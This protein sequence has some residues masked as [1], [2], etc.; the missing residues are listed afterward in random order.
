MSLPRITLVTP[1]Y[2]QAAYLEDTLRSVLLQR[3][4]LHE[5]FVYDGGSSDGSQQVL[6]RYSDAID[7][8]ESGPDGGQSRALAKGF[9]RASGDV[10]AWL[11]SDDVLLPG[12]L[13]AVRQAFAAHP[14][15]DAVTGYFALCDAAGK[16]TRFVWVPDVSERWL[17]LGITRI[18]QQATFVRRE[19]YE[20]VGGLNLELQCVMDTELWYRLFEAGCRWRTV[21]RHLAARRYHEDMKGSTLEERYRVERA[22]LRER[23][24]AFRP[25]GPRAYL[26]QAAH[27][28]TQATAWRQWR[29]A[30]LSWRHR[31]QTAADLRVG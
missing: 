4:E 26:G 15:V 13:R 7:H 29:A 21:P 20:R 9:A 31:G 14:E 28:L 12:A 30:Y 27:R 18:N 19:A 6:E 3:D 23:F 5:Y 22:R 8:W 1:S 16:L 10:L 11:N 24:P 17:R 2:N 25:Q